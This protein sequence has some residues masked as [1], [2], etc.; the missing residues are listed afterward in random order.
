MSNSIK[1]PNYFWIISI[2]ALVWNAMGV[3]AYLNQVN[4]SESFQKMT[5]P[6]QLAA[7]AE[8]PSWVIGAFA[9]AV[10]SGALGCILL[11]IKKRLAYTL[12][13]ISFFAI[14][15]QTSYLFFNPIPDPNYAMTAS[16]IIVALFLVWFSKKSRHKGWLN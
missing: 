3:K 12:F 2:L 7:L 11:L 5:S 8:T 6:E 1:P 10:F 15:T 9:T 13:L 4:N 14:I 16:I